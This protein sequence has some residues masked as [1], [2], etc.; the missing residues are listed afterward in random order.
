MTDF[1]DDFDPDEMAALADE[2]RKAR[3]E[4]DDERASASAQDQK[5][6]A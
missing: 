6:G 1:N 4:I 5:G 3:R 2:E